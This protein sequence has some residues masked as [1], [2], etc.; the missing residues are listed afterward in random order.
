MKTYVSPLFFTGSSKV[1]KINKD[2]EVHGIRNL[3]TIFIKDDQLN[4]WIW[5]YTDN[6]GQ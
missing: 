1:R 5:V 4:V 2:F 3:F 6:M